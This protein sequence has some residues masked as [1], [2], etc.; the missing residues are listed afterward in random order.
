MEF[1]QYHAELIA[2]CTDYY[3]SVDAQ[4]R[5]EATNFLNSV[6]SGEIL[7]TLSKICF[8]ISVTTPTLNPTDNPEYWAF[9]FGLGFFYNFVS[10]SYTFASV[11]IFFF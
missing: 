8:N 10:T 4:K 3:T 9:V 6:S 11:Y 5:K 1:S 7:C 2:K